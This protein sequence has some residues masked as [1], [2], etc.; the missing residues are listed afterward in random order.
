MYGT[1][2]RVEIDPANIE[3]QNARDRL[4]AISDK[5]NGTLSKMTGQDLRNFPDW[6]AWYQKNKNLDWK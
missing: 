3:A 2:A 1:I 6:N 4:A 5:W